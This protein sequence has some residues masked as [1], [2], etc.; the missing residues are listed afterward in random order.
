MANRQRSVLMQRAKVQARAAVE[1]M[2]DKFLAR[3][4]YAERRASCVAAYEAHKVAE[5]MVEDGI[6][7]RH[8]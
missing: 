7:A 6:I 3:T 1:S 4:T 8:W 5:V 2:G